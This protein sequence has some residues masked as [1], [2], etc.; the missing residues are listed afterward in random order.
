MSSVGIQGTPA[1]RIGDDIAHTMA[2]FG[3]IAG[4]IAGAVLVAATVATGGAALVAVAAVAAGAAGG[5]LVGMAVGGMYMGPPTGKLA[6]GSPDVL[7]N[8]RPATMTF[9]ATAS[10][11]HH[12]GS[13]VQV[14]TGSST[15]LI[16][17]C[18]AA[19]EGETMACSAI[20]ISDCSPDVVIGGESVQDPRVEIRPEIP[21]WVVTT[22]TVVAIGGA[23]IATGGAV[24]AAM[25][26][27][28]SFTTAAGTVA[29]GIGRG[30]L[31][32]AIGAGIGGRIGGAIDGERGAVAGAAIGGFLGLPGGR[33]VRAFN[34]RYKVTSQGLGSNFGNLRIQRRQPSLLQGEGKVGRY[35]D[36]V[37]AGRKGDNITPHH[38]PSANHMARHGIKKRDGVAI[39]MEHP[40]PGS[41]G[42]HRSTFTYGTKADQNMSPRDA[43]A[44]GVRD[45]RRIYQEQGL[46]TREI[47]DGLRELI[48]Q[49]K[50]LY[51]NIFGK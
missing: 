49:N 44:A 26:G 1:A 29:L 33:A 23:I 13:P 22:L 11:G 41:G 24:A 31:S 40:H 39:N 10:C 14:A 25:A 8:Y 51:P 36:L 27:G 43:L 37:A 50:A 28:A 30:V 2:R 42:R 48:R 7:I 32:S 17:Q 21:E 5:G 46:Y 9:I 45:A 19:R 18:L 20:I 35:S 47:R 4:M 34:Q 3:L 38:I 15:V 12:S 6:V 16:N